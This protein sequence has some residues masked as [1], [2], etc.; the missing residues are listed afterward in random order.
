[1]SDRRRAQFPGTCV[2]C[3][4]QWAKLTGFV[5]DEVKLYRSRANPGSFYLLRSGSH[6][7]CRSTS[8]PVLT[9]LAARKRNRYVSVRQR[10]SGRESH[11]R[12][13]LVLL[14]SNTWKYENWKSQDHFLTIYYVFTMYLSFACLF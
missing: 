5:T 8:S 3:G 13:Y 9:G 10:K 2:Y 12:S 4:H 14:L 7:G 11:S 1:M 6:E